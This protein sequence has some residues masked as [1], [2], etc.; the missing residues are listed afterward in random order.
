VRACSAVAWGERSMR[1]FDALATFPDS[2]VG[3]AII[4]PKFGKWSSIE[5]ANSPDAVAD[6]HVDVTKNN[7]PVS[8]NHAARVIRA[9]HKRV[10]RRY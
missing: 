8:A 7:G 9:T 2:I 4:L 5:L 1:E 10:G 3:D 6:F